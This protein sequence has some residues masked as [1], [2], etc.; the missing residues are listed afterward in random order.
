MTNKSRLISIPNFPS[1]HL[2]NSRTLR[3][4]LPPSYASEPERHYPVLYMHDGQNLFQPAPLSGFGWNVQHT[5]DQLIADG[6]LQE[7]IVVGIDNTV[8]RIS[9]YIHHDG[10][11]EFAAH[12]AKGQHYEEFLV[13][14]VKPY[15]DTHFRT[16]TDREHTAILGA[17]LGGL[18]SFY[19]GFH[20]PQTFSKIGMMSPSFWWAD[21][22]VLREL[23]GGT[24]TCTDPTKIPFQ[25][26]IDCGDAETSDIPNY[27]VD[28]AQHFT[29]A[30]QALG[31][32]LGDNLRFHITAGAA[33]TE[34]AWRDR[35]H[36]P[37]LYFFG[38][39]A[40]V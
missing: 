31:Y 7:L 18:V 22:I 12:K 4:Y 29:D 17:S 30:F 10:G 24:F 14:E 23:Q 25:L 28:D 20:H 5:A 34:S 32:Q 36:L 38:T 40:N 11:G 2:Q 37:L 6:K 16:L 8:D 13:H 27:M 1:T 35:L 33:H 15:I 19:I 3:V 21:R 26:Y 39:S 9:E